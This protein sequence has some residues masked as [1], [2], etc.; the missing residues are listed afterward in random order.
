MPERRKSGKHWP[1]QFRLVGAAALAIA[2][3]LPVSSCSSSVTADQ[4]NTQVASFDAESSYR[5]PFKELAFDNPKSALILLAYFWPVAA[6]MYR[7]FGRN[8]MGRKFAALE[9]LL[10]LL[11]IYV[12]STLAFLETMEIGA[13]LAFAGVTLYVITTAT[14]FTDKMKGNENA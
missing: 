2:F 8:K 1:G 12:V 5:Y 6:L 9:L 10:C 7:K 13:Y 14:I 3:F 11:S 4:E